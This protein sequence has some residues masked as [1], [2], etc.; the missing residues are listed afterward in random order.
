MTD[1]LTIGAL[2]DETRCSIPT[3]RYYEQVGLMPEANRR[4]GGHRFYGEPD[5]KRLTFIRRCRDF[6][7]SIG[8]GESSGRF[9]GF[10]QQQL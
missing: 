8:E 5:L 7:F 2:A 10:T 9:D 6:G 4:P 3:I 1:I